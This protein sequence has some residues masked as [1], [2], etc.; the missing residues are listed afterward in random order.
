[1]S[2]LKR[3]A[4]RADRDAKRAWARYDR[5]TDGGDAEKLEKEADVADRNAEYLYT[6]TTASLEPHNEE[7]GRR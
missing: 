3:D 5:L 2:E 1:L 7:R 4:Y 6:N